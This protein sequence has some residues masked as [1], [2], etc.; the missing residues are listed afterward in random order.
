MSKDEKD[1]RMAYMDLLIAT[2]NQHEKNLSDYVGRLE[3]IS[4]K[5]SKTD[6]VTREESEIKTFTVK[7][8]SPEAITY[9]KIEVNRSI[10][11][12]TKILATLTKNQGNIKV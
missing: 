12:L 9:I 6:Q 11:D 8:G 7:E 1:N 3:M 10:D 4:N 2:L 5:L